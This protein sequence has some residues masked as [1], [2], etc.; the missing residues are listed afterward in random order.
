MG[1]HGLVIG[2]TGSG[3]SELLRTLVLGLAMTHSPEILNFVLVDFKG[4]A[5]FAGMA[6]M[7]HV[8][9]IITNLA[10]ELDPRR[11]HAGRP[12]RRDDPPPGA[13]P[14]VRQL[15]LAARLRE[16]P[17]VGRPARPRAA[18]QPAHRLRR[19]QR[20][21]LRQAGVHRPV[22]RDRPARPVA[23]RSTCCS[24][25]SGSR[26]A[27]CAAWTATCRTGSACAPS[28]PESRAASSAWATPTSCPPSRVSGSSGPTSRRCCGSRRPTCPG[29]PR[30]VRRG[31][32]WPGRHRPPRGTAVRPRRG[33]LAAGAEQEAA[34]SRA[35]EESAAAVPRRSGPS[36]TSPSSRMTG[37]GPAA[38]R[39]WLPPLDVPDT[40]DQM[41]PGPRGRPRA[42][43]GLARLAL[44]R[45]AAVPARHRRH[46]ARAEAR[47][48][49][50]RPVRR[51]RP[52]RRRRVAA[53]REVDAAA[54]HRHR[55][56]PHAYPSRGAVLRPRLRRWHASPACAT[57]RTSPAIGTRSESDVVTRIVAEVD[58]RRR[59]AGAVLPGQRRRHDRDL[60]QP[61]G[62][63]RSGRRVRR[64]LPGGRRLGHD[65]LGL[66][67]ARGRAPGAGPA[68]P[69]LR[70][71]PGDERDPV[72]GLPHGRSRRARD[73]VRAAARRRDGL[74]DRPQAGR[75]HPARTTRPRHHAGEVPLPRR[76]ALGS[77]ATTTR[78]RSAAA[79]RSSSPRCATPGRVRPARSCG[80]CRPS[81]RR[82]RSGA[83]RRPP[84]RCC[85]ASTSARWPR[86]AW[87]ST[88]TRTC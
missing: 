10:D 61:P 41:L 4:G 59:R 27:G 24:P 53:D 34:A 17:R 70:R 30:V 19:V 72:D 33:G 44:A 21:A 85:S 7:P 42:R 48:A 62:A 52:R 36:S 73:A 15:R 75:Q 54:G 8:S 12:R 68:Q 23:R 40:F 51:G 50:R 14:R 22:R 82:R 38:H 76:P 56:G 37:H 11:P 67:R 9:A 77:T 64:H 28:R 16:G 26:R 20:T 13:A 2:A 55:P 88:A 60:P 65:P 6:G 31:R 32:R 83:S 18:A 35:A 84:R 49:P 79:S 69:D 29:P 25:R 47:D 45:A 81:S 86:S 5:T 1:P 80:C 57:C 87:T 46:A 43:A 71:P 78:G 58:R 39:V 66:R 74:R 3:K 63:G